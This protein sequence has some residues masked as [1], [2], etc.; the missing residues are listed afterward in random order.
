MTKTTYIPYMETTLEAYLDGVDAEIEATIRLIELP[1]PSETPWQLK[2]TV[3]IT[4]V[5][6]PKV[7][8]EVEDAINYTDRK[9][10]IMAYMRLLLMHVN[11]EIQ[12]YIDGSGQGIRVNIERLRK[13]LLGWD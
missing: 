12:K 5:G 4:P 8:T 6:N 11:G 13:E 2:Y 1:G 10:A 9:T 3:K 7:K